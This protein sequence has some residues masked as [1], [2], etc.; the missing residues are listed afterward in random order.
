MTAPMRVYGLDLSY[1]TG[2]F[3]AYLRYKEILHER[4]E[5]SS[6]LLRMVAR[7]T[8]V[9]QMPAVELPDG[10][11]MTDTTPMIEWLE[12]RFESPPVL[13]ADPVLAFLSYLLE[14]YA[15]E[16]LWRPALHYRWSFQ[17]D[18]RLLSD[19]IA[20]E[21]LHDIKAPLALRRWMIYRRQLSK[22]VHGDG[23]TATTRGHVETVYLRALDQL[24]TILAARPFL[25]GGRP[26]LAD[27]GFYG[28]MFRHFGLDPTPSRIMR[29]RA[30][31]VFEWLGRMWN[32]RARRLCAEPLLDRLPDDWLPVLRD[33]GQTYL[34]YLAANAEAFAAGA[35]SFAVAIEGVTYRLPVHRYRVWCLERLQ[36]RYEKLAPDA[37]A[38]VK[39]V[40]Q[41]TGAWSPLWRMSNPASGH[42]PDGRAPFLLPGR[43]WRES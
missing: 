5:L 33:A 40:L 30:P 25:L 1:F 26:S 12:T 28:S 15:D 32:A 29:A 3:E 20:R 39:T 27:F 35:K 18:A 22:Y 8:G 24:E 23:V 31:A 17:P 36:A 7:R 38:R 21:M 41:E 13:P 11:W 42:D 37:Q 43:V 10:R 14:D 2:K 19:R 4:I 16:W 9:A 34:P 6:G